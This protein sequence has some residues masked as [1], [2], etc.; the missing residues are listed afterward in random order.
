MG[1]Y[2]CVSWRRQVYVMRLCLSGPRRGPI[3]MLEEL[4]CKRA[5][6]NHALSSDV[7]TDNLT[8]LPVHLSKSSRL[9]D[10]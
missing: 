6:C 4:S 7:A 9:V 2:V 5:T 3:K 1:M 10:Y 8:N